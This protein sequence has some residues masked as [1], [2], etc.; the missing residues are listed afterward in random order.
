VAAFD[1]WIV[2]LAL[3]APAPISARSGFE[4][5]VLT[6]AAQ[7][8]RLTSEEAAR[9]RPV[10]LRGVV[11]A[12]A[13]PMGH[14]LFIMDTEGLYLRSDTP[15]PAVA[16]GD[17]VEAVG[18]T[19]AGGF[20]PC[21]RL[22]R[23]VRLGTAPIPEAKAATFDELQTGRLDGQWVEVSGIVRSLAPLKHETG[24]SKMVLVSAGGRLPVQI[25]EAEAARAGVDAQV[26]VRG[27]CVH[28]HNTSGQ[29][30]RPT[31]IVPRGE[32]VRVTRARREEAPPL[33]PVA[34][35]FRF[36]LDA[37]FGHRVRVHG[38]VTHHR[39][40]DGLW[41]RDGGRGLR[42]H[43]TSTGDLRVGDEVEALGFPAREA[44]AYT[45]ALED[46]VVVARG[47]GTPPPPVPVRDLATA[48]THDADLVEI[49]GRLTDVRRREEGWSLEVRSG[50]KP[51]RAFLPAGADGAAPDWQVGSQVRAS[52]IGS[53]VTTSAG[54]LAGPWKPRSFQILLRSIEDVRVLQGPPWWTKERLMA[55]LAAVAGTSLLG[56][57][58]VAL[59]ARRRLREQ[60]VRRAMAEAELVAMLAERNR[61]AREIHDTLAQGLGA[62]SMQLEL[63][64]DKLHGPT[65]GVRPHLETAHALVRRSLADARSSIWQMRSQALEERDLAAALEALGRQ[66]ADG[67]GIEVVLR[68]TGRT[69]RLP[70]VT[71]NNLLRIG[72]EAIANAVRHAAARRIEVGL[73]FDEGHVR[74]TVRD[75]GRGFDERRT[76]TPAGGFGLLGMRER[77]AQMHSDLLV[78]TAPGA[79]TE[80]RLN[81][82]VAG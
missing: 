81:V 32:P 56:V 52:G 11:L 62:I 41:I 2:L 20:A 55:L 5:E 67:T 64:R 12:D 35:L 33:V 68:V 15:L 78:S 53:V 60:A 49:E 24:R 79:G 21:V 66:L 31:L 27:V 28:Q 9:A 59:A 40:E 47:R 71:E 57:A 61:I 29:S 1:R 30:L 48:L 17:L 65:D 16:A 18:V 10:R 4:E 74:L 77:A 22:N 8:R 44:G 73:E 23:L 34:G 50:E 63:V 6:R 75:D 43:A 13:N 36:S 82:P 26:L 38:V 39:P 72:Q 76:G 58:G 19:D 54:P 3:F 46:A 42:V 7:V 69:R 70:P 51:V 14:A 80:V 37:A 45:P 25:D